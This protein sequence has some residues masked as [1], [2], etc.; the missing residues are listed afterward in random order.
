M[1]EISKKLKELR[2]SRELTQSELSKLSNI[3][4]AITNRIEN[5]K[6]NPTIKTLSNLFNV[7]G[8]KITVEKV[9]NQRK[10]K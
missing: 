7:L 3:S 2:L 10:D 5:N 9:T 4:F 8:H 1:E 6:S